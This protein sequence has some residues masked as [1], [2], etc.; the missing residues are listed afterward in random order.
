MGADRI[1]GVDS[2]RSQRV[3]F[4]FKQLISIVPSAR[5]IY[6]DERAIV[7]RELKRGHLIISRAMVDG[8]PTVIVLDTGAEIS[9]SNEALRPARSRGR[10]RNPSACR[11]SPLPEKSWPASASS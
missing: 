4:D 2:L 9:M 6:R 3:A 11:W 1:P 8:Q 10:L 5:P 7:V